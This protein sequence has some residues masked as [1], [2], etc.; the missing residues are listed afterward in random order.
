M[1]RAGA[2]IS[3]VGAGIAAS[4]KMAANEADDMGD[5][6][7][8]Y[9]VP[10]EAL[11]RLNYAAGLSDVSLETLG[12]SLKTLSQRMV[13]SPA[14][15]DKLGV[16]IRDASGAMRPTEAV[17]GDL[18][19]VFKTM[20]DGAE[21]TALA[22]SLFGKAGLDMI[23]ML[24]DGSTALAEMGAE[25]DSLGVTISAK[26]AAAA[27]KFNK[28]LARLWATMRG[29]ALQVMAS[30]APA[31][32]DLSEKAIEVSTWFRDLSPDTQALLGKIALF[33]MVLGPALIGL[34]F[35][36][37]S[38]GKVAVAVRA[39]TLLFVANPI[40]SAI[41]VIAA[42]AFLIYENWDE[43]SAWFGEQLEAIRLAF[44]QAWAKVKALTDLALSNVQKIWENVGVWFATTL[45]EVK[46]AFWDIW[47]KIKAMAATWVTDFLAIGGQIVE[48]LKKGISD[49][50]ES[51]V[52]W[53]SGL[54]GALVGDTKAELGI[55]SPS[56]VFQEIGQ[57]VTEGLAIG[58]SDGTAAVASSMDGV[59]SAV[60]G[61]T[62]SLSA[63]LQ[64]VDAW[65]RETFTGLVTGGTAFGKVLDDLKSKLADTLA[66]KAYDLLFGSLFGSFA[67]GAAFSNGSVTAFANGGVVS[68]PTYF[69]MSGGAGLMGEAGPEAIM[70]LTRGANGRLG[71]EAVGGGRSAVEIHLGPGLEGRIL[72]RARGQT[73]ELVSGAMQAQATA[74]PGQM[75][76]LSQRGGSF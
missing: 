53:F 75:D 58:L 4:L 70:P 50:W 40:A 51:L 15:F 29:I 46:Q 72:T 20:P 37:S 57:F 12:T 63:A 9:G 3:V 67:N 69:P 55:H 56:R 33:T 10:I 45:L 16:A 28:N 21:K 41:G 59:T 35:M 30:L 2:A 27:D 23:P 34:G 25:A 13:N 8:K 18:A 76:A 38:L 52:S 71:V 19:D 64:S 66:N 36:V 73:I 5:A 44:E 1:E 47:E 14:S 32:V 11:S 49:K 22:V 7:Q 43:L 6:A 17:L 31:M 24:A 48:G 61:A 26:T 74:L 60:A 68:A 62:G 42:G 39:L 65:G 54:T